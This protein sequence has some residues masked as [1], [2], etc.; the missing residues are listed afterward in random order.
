MP[1]GPVKIVGTIEKGV[2]KFEPGEDPLG[3][4]NIVTPEFVLK[5]IDLAYEVQEL[6]LEVKRLKELVDKENHI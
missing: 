6:K 2:P 4:Y 5:L 3:A 1:V